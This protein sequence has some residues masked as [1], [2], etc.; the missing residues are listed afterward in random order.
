MGFS[1]PQASQSPRGI[2]MLDPAVRARYDLYR[3]T[4]S[5]CQ[6][7]FFPELD[8]QGNAMPIRFGRELSHVGNWVNAN[9]Y[10][11]SYLG[12]G[13]P[14]KEKVTMLVSIL[15]DDK[16]SDPSQRRGLRVWD[17]LRNTLYHRLDQ[18][19]APSHWSIWAASRMD[20]TFGPPQK[21]K[22]KPICFARGMLT[23]YMT[24]KGPMR[25][26]SPQSPKYC[27]IFFMGPAAQ[28]ALIIAAFGDQPDLLSERLR[29]KMQQMQQQTAVG[30]TQQQGR[31]PAPRGV[32]CSPP[33]SPKVSSA[34]PQHT[35]VPPA[36][37]GPP[38]PGQAAAA[39]A[40]GPQPWQNQPGQTA[41]PVGSSEG[42]PA[43]TT[44]QT[45]S[46]TTVAGAPAAVVS[47]PATDPPGAPAQPTG[48][49]AQGMD[50]MMAALQAAGGGA[51]DKG[52]TPTTPGQ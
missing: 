9:H 19:T 40:G 32:G 18:G 6:V 4:Q 43:E 15:G 14:S 29:A 26:V 27:C 51:S 5:G 33:S 17:Q 7:R 2:M 3:V 47:V 21:S 24:S 46:P 39:S 38:L 23:W 10:G 8:A 49:Q 31:S 37:G 12:G 42:A 30:Y 36:V 41:P 48:V 34:L 1:D 35:T 13:D 22:S 45:S 16:V 20:A 28:T 25:N 11:I 50:E 52:T 44:P